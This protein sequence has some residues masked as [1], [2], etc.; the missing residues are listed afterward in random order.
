MHGQHGVQLGPDSEPSQDRVSLSQ[1]DVNIIVTRFNVV[2]KILL[3]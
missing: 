1:D 2:F 3:K